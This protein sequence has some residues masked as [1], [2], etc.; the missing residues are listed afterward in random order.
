MSVG[1]GDIIESKITCKEWGH[2]KGDLLRVREHGDGGVFADNLTRPHLSNRHR[3]GAT[4]L[5]FEYRVK[6]RVKTEPCE[7][8][9]RSRKVYFLG[10]PIFTIKEAE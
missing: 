7:K 8:N 2:V 4:L 3:N 5:D 9:I 6:S 10:I 1:K